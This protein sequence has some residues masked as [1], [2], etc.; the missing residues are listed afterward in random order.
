MGGTVQHQR[1]ENRGA[2]VVGTKEGL[3][4]QQPTSESGEASW[5]GSKR[6]SQQH[7]AT[8]LK[9][10]NCDQK[11]YIIHVITEPEVYIFELVNMIAR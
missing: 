9:T 11:S 3:A 6:M 10:P 8:N 1:R 2:E 5:E 7:N 4:H